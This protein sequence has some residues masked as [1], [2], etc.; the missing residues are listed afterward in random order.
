[1]SE[2]NIAK[3]TPLTADDLRVRLHG[4]FLQREEYTPGGID[5]PLGWHEYFCADG[6]WSQRGGR[7]GAYGHFTIEDNILCVESGN[8]LQ[9]R[10]RTFTSDRTGQLYAQVIAD[11]PPPPIRVRTF[12][13]PLTNCGTAAN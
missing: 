1:M 4:N 5:L 7:V 3:R 11:D 9:H 13:D 8:G 2:T 12:S 10:C 6:R